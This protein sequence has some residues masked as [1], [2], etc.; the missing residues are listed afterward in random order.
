MNRYGASVF[1]AGVVGVLLHGPLAIFPLA[2]LPLAAQGSLV[3]GGSAPSGAGTGNVQS[4]PL[5]PPPGLA[6]P[7]PP[8]AETRPAD[9]P[10]ATQTPPAGAGQPPA[11]ASPPVAAPAISAPP[12]AIPAVPPPAAAVEPVPNAAPPV[13]Q[14][15]PVDPNSTLAGKP[16]DAVNVD[17]L[18]LAPK[19]AAVSTGKSTWDE[20]PKTLADTF[21]RMRAEAE[22]AGVKVAGRPLAIFV[23]TDDVSFRFEAFLP[24]DRIPDNRDLLGPDI[25]ISQTPAGRALRFVHKG[26]YDDVDSTYEVIT[27]YLDTK[28]ITVRDAFIEEYV[29]DLKDSSEAGFEVNIY[30]VP[31]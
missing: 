9:N 5:A 22:K 21:A 6:A 2:I 8:P 26:P 30:V 23:E 25:R 24:I 15:G 7:V 10:A 31:R 3:P 29:G 12:I 18:T 20:G 17:D 11:I 27:A 14:S 19:N 16:G 28:G 1:R 13:V 4:V